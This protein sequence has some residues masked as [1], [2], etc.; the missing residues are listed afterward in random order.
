MLLALFCACTN[1]SYFRKAVIEKVLS[2]SEIEVKKWASVPCLNKHSVI[3]CT[4]WKFSFKCLFIQ[5]GCMLMHV[6][7]FH[8]CEKLNA[9]AKQNTIDPSVQLFSWCCVYIE[10]KKLKIVLLTEKISWQKVLCNY[11]QPFTKRVWKYFSSASL[12]F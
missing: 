2:F 5:T 8:C 7:Y 4:S 6:N 10:N 12:C 11:K 3:I 9:T 1:T